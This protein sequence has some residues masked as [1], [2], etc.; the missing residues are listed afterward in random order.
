MVV[1]VVV[2]VIIVMVI[3]VRCSRRRCRCGSSS[4]RNSCWSLPRVGAPRISLWSCL[5]VEDVRDFGSL[6]CLLLRQEP[7]SS[8]QPPV[9]VSL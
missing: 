6:D 2:V 5:E 1:V 3:I 7:Q 4:P 9:S 8:E